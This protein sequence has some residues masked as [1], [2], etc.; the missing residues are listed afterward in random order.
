MPAKKALRSATRKR[1]FRPA[2]RKRMGAGSSVAADVAAYIA[3]APAPARPMLRTLRLIIRANAPQAIEKIS[4]Q[5]PYYHHH[6]RLI[7]FAAFSKHVSVFVMNRAKEPFAAEMKPYR[8]SAA[9]LQ[10]PFGVKIPERLIAK[11]VRA[12]VRENETAKSK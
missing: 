7:Y 2:P 9:T 10:F 5:M 8:T 1:S 11:L 12:R 6:G 3:A 4:Y